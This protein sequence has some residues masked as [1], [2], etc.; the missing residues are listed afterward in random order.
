[1]LRHNNPLDRLYAGLDQFTM[2][3]RQTL[4]NA[5]VPPMSQPTPIELRDWYIDERISVEEALDRAR[6]ALA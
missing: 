3:V 4:V 2:C 5:G 1:M 6:A